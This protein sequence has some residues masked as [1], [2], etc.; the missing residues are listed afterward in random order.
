VWITGASSG[1][2]QA[3]A[4]ELAAQGATLL[5]TARRVDRLEAFKAAAPEP[6]RVHLLPADLLDAG[7]IEPL[8]RDAEKV[9]GRIDVLI[10]NAGISQRATA[11]DTRIQDVRRLMEV[12]FFAPVALTNAVLPG[13][14]ERRSGWI[15]VLSSVAGYVG[16]PLRSS[17]AASKH[18]VRGYFD[19]L[20]AEL[21]ATGVG[22]TIA[23]PGYIQTEITERAI[24]AG[25]AEHG[26][27]DRVI[28]SGLPADVCARTILSAVDRGKS[29]VHV[30][31]REVVAIYL[32]RLL[33]GLVERV[34][35]RQAPS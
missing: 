13:M 26:V 2:G 30:G 20:R 17:Y 15:V 10:N 34:V 28:E 1:I 11:L 27:R 9:A 7:A 22:V 31:G 18:A 35:P 12:N 4:A 33:P 29:E 21:H 3:L 6:T 32:K 24:A 16:T 8:A 23:C 19:S 14:V 5:L 25:G